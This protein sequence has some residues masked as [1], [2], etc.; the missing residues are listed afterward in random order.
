MS[1]VVHL[2]TTREEAITAIKTLINTGCTQVAFAVR[3]DGVMQVSWPTLPVE[4]VK[5]KA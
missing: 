5:E 2:C 1:I 4:P 3:Q